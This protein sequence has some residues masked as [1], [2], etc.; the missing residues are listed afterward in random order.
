MRRTARPPSTTAAVGM[1]VLLA[2]ACAGSLAGPS[3]LPNASPA[4]SARPAA[5]GQRPARFGGEYAGLDERRR[6]LVDDW[7]GRFNEVTGQEVEPGAFYD[8]FV[9]LSAKTTFDAVTHALMTTSLTDASGVR[10]G[11]ALDLVEHVEAVRGQVVAARGDQ[12]FRMYARLTERALDTLVRSR[13]FKRGADN[14]VY[15]KGYPINYRQQ[16]GTPSIQFSMSLDERRADIDVDYRSSSFPAALFNGHLTSANSDVRAGTNSERHSSRWAGFQNWWRSFFGIRLRDDGS[17]PV[18]EDTSP[19]ADPPRAGKAPVTVM[20]HDF[21]QAWL[22]EGNAI[23]AS[24]YVAERA[25]SCLALESDDPASF[26]RGMAP[27]MLLMRL[28]DA[29]RALGARASLEGLIV[30]VRL[31]MPELR[32]VRQPHHAQFVV[33]EVPDDV[34]AAFDCQ[35]QLT[36]GDPK[37]VGR[38]YGNYYGTVFYVD[39]ARD[40]TLALLWGRDRG[41]WKIVSWRAELHGDEPAPPAAPPDVVVERIDADDSLVD[42]ANDFLESWLVRKDYDRAFKYLSRASYACYDLARQPD[43]PAAPSVDDAGRKIRAGLEASGS[44]V[45]R[46]RALE[47]VITAAEPFHPSIKVMRHRHD[48]TFAL[49]SVPTALADAADCAARARGQELPRNLP[50]EYGKAFGMTIRFLTRGG[51]APVLRTLWKREEGAWRIAAYD[52]E[53]P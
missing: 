26:D 49:A 46:I 13:E 7:V 6:R 45:G 31:A 16:G 17:R 53:L 38:S 41:Y 42:A 51:D 1:G 11:D 28:R 20:A 24:A 19:L 15:H 29:H 12:Q 44:R 10:L 34:A 21:L 36:L 43:E 52:V 14:T 18:T 23:A 48:R 50:L 5:G 37:S 32:V 40:H 22:V 39:G 4:A 33:Y 27:F 8:M 9:P 35:N 30:G 2:V 25:Y 47:D 3:R